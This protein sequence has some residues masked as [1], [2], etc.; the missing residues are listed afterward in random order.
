M[1]AE[2]ETP[3]LTDAVAGGACEVDLKWLSATA[4]RGQGRVYP[5][6]VIHWSL[7]NS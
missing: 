4:F 3:W 7:K 5:F 6:A 1:T 2:M